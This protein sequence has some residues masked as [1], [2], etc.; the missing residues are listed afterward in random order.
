M[1]CRLSGRRHRS[2]CPPSG[3]Q[4]RRRPRLALRFCRSP[5]EHHRHRRPEP[6]R[7]LNLTTVVDCHRPSSSEPSM[8][9]PRRALHIGALRLRRRAIVRRQA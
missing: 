2:G 5:P 6:L 3:S 4:D 9:S 1:R 7:R 8:S